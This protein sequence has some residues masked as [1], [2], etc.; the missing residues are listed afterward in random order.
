MGAVWVKPIKVLQ[1]EDYTALV[2]GF[3]SQDPSG[4]PALATPTNFTGQTAKLQV[5]QNALTSST[6][7]LTLTSGSGITL[8]G[9]TT[10]AGVSCGTI[11]LTL[12]ATQT[13]GLPA[14]S[15]FYD[16]FCVNAGKNK[17]YMQG[18]FEVGATGSR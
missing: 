6:L 8:G 18:P 4:N 12:T 16:L 13:S 10:L 11:T 15:W 3:A 14:G 2:Y 5:R 17:Y 1:N 7:F 9:P